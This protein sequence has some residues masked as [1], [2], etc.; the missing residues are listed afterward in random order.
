MANGVFAKS[1]N[2]VMENCAWANCASSPR[3]LVK[4]CP[5]IPPVSIVQFVRSC[6]SISRTVSWMASS[7]ANDTM[8]SRRSLD[9][10]HATK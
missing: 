9:A 4:T 8:R 5:S 2:D 3:S 1:A 7:T 6:W 10:Q